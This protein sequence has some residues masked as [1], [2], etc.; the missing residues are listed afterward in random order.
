[1]IRR[2]PRST[3]FPYTTLFRSVDLAV[4]I[5]ARAL[6]RIAG[7]HH[8][9]V[10]VAIRPREVRRPD[11][12]DREVDRVW[13]AAGVAVDPRDLPVVRQ[14]AQRAT[15][16]L[17]R[18]VDEV[19]REAVRTVELRVGV[20]GPADLRG[21]DVRTPVAAVAVADAHGLAPDVEHREHEPI[22]EAA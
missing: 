14:H 5:A 22:V 15:R 7:E 20:V 21:G 1:M 16:D 9:R 6:A 17:R 3:L 19:D 2:P 4:G 12:R 18:L 8:A 10:L 13:P 11:A